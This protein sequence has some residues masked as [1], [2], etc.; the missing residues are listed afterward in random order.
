MI[1]KSVLMVYVP[2]FFLV[3]VLPVCRRRESLWISVL[4]P[5]VSAPFNY[6]LVRE[7]MPLILPGETEGFLGIIRWA[8]I[9]LYILILTSMEEVI[10]GIAGRVI[11]RRQRRMHIPVNVKGE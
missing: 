1:L 3:S 5:A 11:W 7:Y 4:T 6:M 10:A 9:L 2:L 8:F